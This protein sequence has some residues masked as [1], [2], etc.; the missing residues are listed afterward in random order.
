MSGA[1]TESELLAAMVEGRSYRRSDVGSLLVDKPKAAVHDALEGLVRKGA[2]WRTY[3]GKRFEYIRLTLV[4]L[5]DMA[6][7]KADRSDMPDWMKK[8]LTGYGDWLDRHRA[9]AMSTR[10]TA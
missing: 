6:Q 1:V 5:T 9:L 4:Q 8:T 7:R 3:V 10:R 2:V